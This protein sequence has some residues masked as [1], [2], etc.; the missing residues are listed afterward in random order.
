VVDT[1]HGLR[2]DQEPPREGGLVGHLGQHGLDRDDPVEHLVDG[3]PDLAHPA[4]ADPGV[5]AVAVT[6]SEPS[7]Q[8]CLSPSVLGSPGPIARRRPIAAPSCHSG[9]RRSGQPIPAHGT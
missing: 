9:L 6:E 5:E 4:G 7:V 3:P 8:H 1:G 2:L